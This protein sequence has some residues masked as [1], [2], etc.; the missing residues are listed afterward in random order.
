MS[1]GHQVIQSGPYTLPFD[2]FYT[3][4]GYQW[5]GYPGQVHEWE[6]WGQCTTARAYWL[7]RVSERADRSLRD[8]SGSA[9]SAREIWEWLLTIAEIWDNASKRSCSDPLDRVY[10]VYGLLRNMGVEIPRPDYSKTVSQIVRELTFST[11][12]FCGSFA[13]LHYFADQCSRPDTTSWAVDWARFDRDTNFR[14]FWGVRKQD[15]ATFQKSHWPDIVEDRLRMKAIL[16]STKPFGTT[17]PCV[18]VQNNIPPGRYNAYQS[19]MPKLAVLNWLRETMELAKAFQACPDGQLACQAVSAALIGYRGS[20][21]RGLVSIDDRSRTVMGNL[22]A[23]GIV[24]SSPERHS[25]IIA[26]QSQLDTPRLRVRHG[27]P[28]KQEDAHFD[29]DEVMK[30]LM[31]YLTDTTS[32]CQGGGLFSTPEGWDGLAMRPVESGDVLARIHGSSV[33][34]ILRPT[35]EY[36]RLLC[37]AS[38]EGIPGDDWSINGDEEGVQSIELI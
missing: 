32:R 31:F 15:F 5:S 22:L 12:S 17:V 28:I 16:S 4:S 23:C 29:D 37:F 13:P 19:A 25:E 2:A 21:D 11:I 24:A 36:F 33:P 26:T 20:H 3:S 8:P 30:D 9:L 6:I 38:M 10:G 7:D 34:A 1:S 18:T 35:G 27:E 14:R